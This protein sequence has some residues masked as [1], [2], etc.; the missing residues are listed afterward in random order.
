M[1]QAIQLKDIAK[2]CPLYHAS[3]MKNRKACLC[4]K[5]YVMLDL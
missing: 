4:A 3:N 2:L 1:T 5:K